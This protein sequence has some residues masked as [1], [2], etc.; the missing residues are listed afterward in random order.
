MAIVLTAHFQP[1]QTQEK[2]R[3]KSGKMQIE[4]R[5]DE[6]GMAASPLRLP[7]RPPAR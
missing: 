5:R 1:P 6:I 3:K 7:W 4:M 2:I